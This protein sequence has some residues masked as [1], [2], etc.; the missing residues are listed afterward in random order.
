MGL[1]RAEHPY[2]YT[3]LFNLHDNPARYIDETHSTDQDTEA[4]SGEGIWS[5]AHSWDSNMGLSYFVIRAHLRHCGT[6]YY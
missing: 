5:M 6:F 2:A 4:Q 1:L 3:A